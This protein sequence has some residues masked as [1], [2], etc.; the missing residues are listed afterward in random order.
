M[1]DTYPLKERECVLP[2]GGDRVPDSQ[3]PGDAG[4]EEGCNDNK[5]PGNIQDKWNG[6]ASL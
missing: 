6:A 3:C 5:C 1:S 4:M 2:N